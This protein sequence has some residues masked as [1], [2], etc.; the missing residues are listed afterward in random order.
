MGT[1]VWIFVCVCSRLE[2]RIY[3]YKPCPMSC[4]WSRDIVR[5]P[6]LHRRSTG[7]PRKHRK[8]HQGHVYST[9]LHE[10]R[11]LDILTWV[12]SA[13]LDLGHETYV[14]RP[15]LRRHWTGR[16]RKHRKRHKDHVCI[17]FL[18][19]IKGWWLYHSLMHVTF[20]SSAVR[21]LKW[22]NTKFLFLILLRFLK[23]LFYYLGKWPL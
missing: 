19:E 8:W 5:R 15:R 7:R 16:P 4:V 6:R 11:E 17:V 18:H 9:F 3:R 20:I 13:I 10:I 23:F 1:V 12:L 22:A 21:G 2:D 14:R